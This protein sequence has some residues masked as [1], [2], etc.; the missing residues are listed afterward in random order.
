MKSLKPL[1]GLAMLCVGLGLNP[2]AASAIDLTGVYTGTQVCTYFDGTQTGP[3]F[4]NDVLLIT[5]SGDDLFFVSG[6]V[7]AIFH[8]QVI[9][10][11]RS[12]ATKAQ[13]VFIA[14]PTADGSDYQELGRATKLEANPRS[15]TGYFQATSNFFETDP[16]GFRFMGTC[17]WTYRQTSTDDPG[18]PDCSA[19]SS[20][21][22]GSVGRK[23][24]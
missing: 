1:A 20:L 18:V 23:R 9:E 3:R 24:P 5:Q 8:A 17:Q 13:A 22:A 21:A 2:A 4:P 14:C 12:P 10:D 7:G 16:D 11:V 19:V 6:I 15:V